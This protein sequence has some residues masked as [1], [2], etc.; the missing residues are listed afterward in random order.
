M[1][2]DPGP[3]CFSCLKYLGLEPKVIRIGMKFHSPLIHVVQL[4]PPTLWIV[5]GSLH[6]TI[7]YEQ[8]GFSVMKVWGSQMCHLSRWD[9]H[10][11]IWIGGV[12][13]NQ[14][15]PRPLHLLPR[16][17]GS[18]PAWD[19]ISPTHHPSGPSQIPPTRKICRSHSSHKKVHCAYWVI[20]YKEKFFVFFKTR[21]FFS[22]AISMHCNN[23]GRGVH[24]VDW[25]TCGLGLDEKCP[26]H[27]F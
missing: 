1:V 7:L 17:V 25:G 8:N 12:W 26:I 21:N 16:P 13:N 6:Q 14:N 2:C 5:V 4:V 22:G 19:E 23:G 15:H 9:V 27:S 11:T 3:N 10:G 20:F 24:G 18:Q